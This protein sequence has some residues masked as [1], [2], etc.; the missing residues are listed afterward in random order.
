M[1][2]SNSLRIDVVDDDIVEVMYEYYYLN[3]SD[4]SLPDGVSVTTY[5]YTRIHIR[6]DDCKSTLCKFCNHSMTCM[7]FV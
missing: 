2:R 7:Y 1:T 4:N 3:I 5:K 6:D